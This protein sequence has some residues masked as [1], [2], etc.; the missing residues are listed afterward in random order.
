M[1]GLTGGE[2]EG[3]ARIRQ[4]AR[5]PQQRTTGGEREERGTSTPSPRHVPPLSHRCNDGY[6]GQP[7]RE[8][9]LPVL[10]A[11]AATQ[12]S[13]GRWFWSRKVSI[14][15]FRELQPFHLAEVVHLLPVSRVLA[16]RAIHKSARTFSPLS[17][18][19]RAP[20]GRAISAGRLLAIS[21]ED[22]RRRGAA[23]RRYRVAGS[24]AVRWC[25][26][27]RVIDG[28][29]SRPVDGGTWNW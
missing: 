14:K 16:A 21:R 13:P 25:M 7:S 18:R 8:L 20:R 12:Q 1:Q 3:E 10:V 28:G 26:N 4:R 23:R 5:I 17:T 11:L 27:D 19:R 22:T 6:C 9:V 29:E 15:K 2:Q 24:R